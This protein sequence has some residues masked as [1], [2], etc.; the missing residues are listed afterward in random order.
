M[1][2][3]MP[4]RTDQTTNQAHWLVY[5]LKEYLPRGYKRDPYG[6]VVLPNI[7]GVFAYWSRSRN[8][9]VQAAEITGHQLIP[10]PDDGSHDNGLWH[11]A[12]DVR[13]AP[14]GYQSLIYAP[15]DGTVTYLGTPTKDGWCLGLEC[16][17]GDR[18]L[19]FLFQHV[20]KDGAKV[21]DV[22]RAGDIITYMHDM[23]GD[24]HLHLECYSMENLWSERALALG[25]DKAY[26]IQ[27]DG[28][29]PLCQWKGGRVPAKIGVPEPKRAILY[30]PY[31]LLEDLRFFNG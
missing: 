26:S 24:T 23:D 25:V 4:V 12:V 5:A 2:T 16:R 19:W 29:A 11:G 9:L 17:V 20:T 7:P 3:C 1:I 18:R 31:R 15:L 8:R 13:P 14:N 30:N 21:G 6:A 10:P 27:Y 28:K 22:V